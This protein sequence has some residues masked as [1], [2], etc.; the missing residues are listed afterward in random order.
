MGL[1]GGQMQRIAIAR[2]LLKRPQRQLAATLAIGSMALA[3]LLACAA[4][5]QTL[6]EHA[7]RQVYNF[8]WFQF[9]D[10]TLQLGWVL[11]PLTA[12]MLV[13]ITLVGGLIFIYSVGYMAHDENFTRFFCF[14]SL[15]AAGMLG[16][17]IES[18]VNAETQK[19]IFDL[20]WLGATSFIVQ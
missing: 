11:D 13:M 17:V 19:A 10:T 2:A 9:G 20:A 12:S 8:P 4:F 5:G 7:Q 1:S 6:G 18:A 15:F 16:V 3:F 14:L